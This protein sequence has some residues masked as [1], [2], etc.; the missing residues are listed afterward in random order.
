MSRRDN[1]LN[2]IMPLVLIKSIEID[3]S[4]MDQAFDTLIGDRHL[5]RSQRF[6]MLKILRLIRKP[7]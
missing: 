7:R 1:R 2:R 6:G 3:A 4:H 5:I